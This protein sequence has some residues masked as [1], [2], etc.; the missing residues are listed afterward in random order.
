MSIVTRL[1]IRY[2]NGIWFGTY[3]KNDSSVVSVRG[4]AIKGG[5]ALSFMTLDG[6]FHHHYETKN[7]FLTDGEIISLIEKII[8]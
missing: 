5:Y 6:I 8:V 1:P 7:G 4:R 2:N 3:I